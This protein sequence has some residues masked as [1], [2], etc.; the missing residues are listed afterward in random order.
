ME[1]ES[2]SELVQR[3]R[4]AVSQLGVKIW[5]NNC[6]AYKDPKGY[7]VKYGVANPGGA[8]LIGI[9]PDGRFVGIEC[10]MPKGVVKPEQQNFID[11]VKKAGGIAGI[12]RSEEEAIALFADTHSLPHNPSRKP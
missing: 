4:L 7:W 12:V 2:E 5:R 11:Q 9:A 10:K 1:A 6:G 3:V 8:D